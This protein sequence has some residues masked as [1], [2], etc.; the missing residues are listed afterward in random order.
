MVLHGFTSNFNQRRSSKNPHLFPS[1]FIVSVAKRLLT[2]Q[3]MGNNVSVFQ[4]CRREPNVDESRLFA[5]NMIFTVSRFFA[6][7]PV[8]INTKCS[9]SNI[10]RFL[11]IPGS[12]NP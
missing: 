5:G 10:S 6:S 8:E 1:S 11:V 4:K 2:N 7:G 12:P 3:R 9:I